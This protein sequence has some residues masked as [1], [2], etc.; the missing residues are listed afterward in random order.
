[1][2][3]S[4]RSI[5]ASGITFRSKAETLPRVPAGPTRRPL[6]RNS[7]RLA[8]RPRRESVCVPRP[9][10]VTNA[11]EVAALTW[12]EPAAIVDDCS[13]VPTSAMPCMPAFSVV[14]TSIGVELLKVSRLMREPVTMTSS[15]TVA[16]AWSC[17]SWSCANA[18]L[19]VPRAPAASTQLMEYASGFLL[20]MDDLRPGLPGLKIRRGERHPSCAPYRTH[21]RARFS[22]PVNGYN[23][24]GFVP[25]GT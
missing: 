3:I 22:T 20:N 11:V 23:M 25:P 19:P 6:S 21:N 5:A 14:T 15:T 1:M 8:P 13:S 9:P 12:D 24:R 7:V 4:T 2:R 18:R 10:F 17:A 16:S